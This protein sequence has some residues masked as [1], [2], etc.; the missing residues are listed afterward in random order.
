M[1]YTLKFPSNNWVS[2]GGKVRSM[3]LS[4]IEW[5]K[6]NLVHLVRR[7]ADYNGHELPRLAR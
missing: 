6:A 3:L 7:T 1:S 5:R 4:S 2:S